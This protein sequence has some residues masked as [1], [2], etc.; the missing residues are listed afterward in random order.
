[1]VRLFRLLSCL[2]LISAILNPGTLFYGAG[3]A[4][5]VIYFATAFAVKIMLFSLELER[6]R[7]FC[8]LIFAGSGE[9]ELFEGFGVS[10]L[11]AAVKLAAI[12]LLLY[13]VRTAAVFVFPA[14]FFAFS[15]YLMGK[16]VSMAVAVTLI[17]GNLAVSALALLFC[18]ALNGCVRCVCA[19]S[20]FEKER[21]FSA[22]RQRLRGLDYGCFRLLRVRLGC[23]QPFSVEK[24]LLVLLE[25]DSML[26]KQQ[27]QVNC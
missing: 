23:A 8:R 18:V 21:L 10:D 12:R 6:Q 14:L 22:V 26:G 11:L 24:E 2:L 5:A 20:C 9:K 27:Q 3:G 7:W 4:V 13:G 17:A 1:M 16:G 19:C 15:L 25:A